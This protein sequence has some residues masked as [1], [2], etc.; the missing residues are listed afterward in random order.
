MIDT[1]Q[2]CSHI[3]H[4]I[5]AP[6]HVYDAAGTQINVYVDHGEQQDVIER[7]EDLRHLLLNK[8][9]AEY[10]VL[11]LEAEQI[12]YG[13]V[14]DDR[15][16]YLLGP[17]CLKHVEK[18]AAAYLIK[19]HKMDSLKPYRVS[20]TTLNTFCEM[21][22]ML[23]EALTGQSITRDEL[24]QQ[25]FCDEKMIHAMK[26]K[27]HEVFDH[28]RENAVVHNPYGQEAREQ[29]AIRKG[30]LEA[31]KKSFQEIYVGEIGI[32]S[33]DPLRHEKNL[34]I[35]L[36]TLASR[37]AIAGGLLP[38]IAFS[39]SDAF[40]QHVEEL[41]DIAKVR[42]FGRQAEVEYCKAVRNLSFESKKNPFIVRCKA[43]ILQRLHSKLSV[44]ELAEELEI[45]PGYLSHL[46]LKE[47]GIK[48]TEY[49]TRE[50][51]NFAKEQLICTDNSLDA[52]AYS[53][54]FV[55]QSHFGK[56]FKKATGMTPKQ[57]RESYKGNQ[58]N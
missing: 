54:C 45:T 35:V 53:L 30:D 33:H 12:I 2:L 46:F 37:S 44:Q 6:I 5:H 34:A 41:K 17:C 8:G 43:L 9:K 49:I 14:S 24:L 19:A 39:M 18:E 32:L 40:I 21:V 55:S 42:A 7:D 51:I 15:E 22:M 38:E 50:K 52:I 56:T 10:P 58:L 3:I 26:G 4:L 31:L 16:T 57:Y 47:E 28:L 36:I 48:L 23:F 11:Y 27:V 29:E 25:C 1:E 20:F 13:I